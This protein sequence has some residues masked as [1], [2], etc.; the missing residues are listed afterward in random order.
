MGKITLGSIV[1]SSRSPPQARSE[2]VIG[3]FPS[4]RGRPPPASSG[5]GSPAGIVAKW[6]SVV[7]AKVVV[8]T[9]QRQGRCL[10]VHL[11]SQEEVPA[12]V[13]KRRGGTRH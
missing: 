9:L 7:V 10:S 2:G 3:Q 1:L 13:A 8:R 12:V 5:S 11:S 6:A 4:D